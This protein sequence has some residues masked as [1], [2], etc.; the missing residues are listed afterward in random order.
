MQNT[1]PIVASRQK[2][3]SRRDTILIAKFNEY[4]SLKVEG[5]RPDI[6]QVYQRLADDFYL[7]L[8]RVKAIIKGPPPAKPTNQTNLF[9]Q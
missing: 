2:N 4:M 3:I 6:D 9:A 7:S 1:S 8:H 5:F